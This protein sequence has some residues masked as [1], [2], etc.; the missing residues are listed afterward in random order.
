MQAR[1]QAGS[2]VTGDDL[3]DELAR[4]ADEKER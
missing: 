1:L 4:L 2:T 3:L